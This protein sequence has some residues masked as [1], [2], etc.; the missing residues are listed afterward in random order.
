M[1]IISSLKGVGYG[2]AGQPLPFVSGQD[3]EVPS[4]KSIIKGEQYSTIFKDTRELAKVTVSMIEAVLQGKQ[5]EVND[6]KTYDNGV[7]IV[8]SYLLKPVPVDGSN[9]K[10]VLVDSGYYTEA[11]LK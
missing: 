8:P 1:G 11:Q 2:T 4:V 7:K 9:W 5:P 6:T 10:A 3:A